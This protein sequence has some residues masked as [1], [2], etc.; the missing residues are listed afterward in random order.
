MNLE[1]KMLVRKVEAKA[2]SAIA[3]KKSSISSKGYLGMIISV[4]SLIVDHALKLLESEKET[5]KIREEL[6]QS[7]C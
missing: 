6:G 4:S 3:W 7:I 1:E 2:G 5:R